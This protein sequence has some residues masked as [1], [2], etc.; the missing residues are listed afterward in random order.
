MYEN[1]KRYMKYYNE[2]IKDFSFKKQ[3]YEL[4]LLGFIIFL[5]IVIDYFFFGVADE[6]SNMF[7]MLNVSIENP[8]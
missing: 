1:L 7:S 4:I 5:L 2:T 8:R 3:T 6:T